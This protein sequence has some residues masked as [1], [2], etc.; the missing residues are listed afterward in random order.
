MAGFGG[1]LLM[2]VTTL[3]IQRRKEVPPSSGTIILIV[4]I[5]CITFGTLQ[6]ATTFRL[7]KFDEVDYCN[8][9]IGAVL[10]ALSSLAVTPKIPE[11][12]PVTLP[13]M[14]VGLFFLFGG[15]HYAFQ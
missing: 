5:A 11:E 13:A 14:I 6:E 4:L 2:I 12:S 15:F 9:N 7:A 3:E 10:A 8:Q 1:T